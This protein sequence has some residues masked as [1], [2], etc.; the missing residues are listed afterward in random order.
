MKRCNSLVVLALG[1]LIVM[2]GCSST[3]KLEAVTDFDSSFDFIGVKKVAIQPVKR[4][5]ASA[6]L[7]SDMDVNRL[8]QV[9]TEQLNFRGIDVVTDNADADMYL[10]WHLVTQEKTDVRSYNSASYYNCWRCGPTVSDI[11]VRQ[12][13][14]GTLIVDMIDPA[15]G[16]SVWRST[17]Q[18]KLKSQA[19]AEDDGALRQE[20]GRALFDQFPPY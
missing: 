20:A 9:F 17:V 14:E 19:S 10:V 8:N 11:S 15:R 6:V 16:Q 12:Y 1:A 5:N 7:I 4:M 18:S 13:T 3:P 2:T